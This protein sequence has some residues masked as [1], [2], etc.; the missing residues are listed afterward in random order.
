MQ[1]AVSIPETVRA[2]GLYTIVDGAMFFAPRDLLDTLVSGF[3]GSAGDTYADARI[4]V[5]M[6]CAGL[7]A[8]LRGSA[9]REVLLPFQKRLVR[10]ASV[11]D[12]VAHWR[13]L[14]ALFAADAR[15]NTV[16][17]HRVFQRCGAATS[18]KE[19]AARP[20]AAAGLTSSMDTGFASDSGIAL[21]FVRDDATTVPVRMREIIHGVGSYVGVGGDVY[22]VPT[23]ALA[24]LIVRRSPARLTSLA[25]YAAATA[26]AFAHLPDALADSDPLRESVPFLERLRRFDTTEAAV[27]HRTR[28]AAMFLLP[29]SPNFTRQSEARFHFRDADTHCDR[30]IGHSS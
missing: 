23:A 12:A 28:I 25:D 26:A 19:L 9:R 18:I 16:P 20:P 4:A 6:A 5:Y 27:A 21:T 1:C 8:A 17:A 24:D 22:F 30:W 2:V 29:P 11:S 15:M 13:E 3:L 7:P 14:H 10:L